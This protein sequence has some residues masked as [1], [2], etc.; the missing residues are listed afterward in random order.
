MTKEWK[1][2]DFSSDWDSVLKKEEA[3][4]PNYL[5][6]QNE[7]KNMP[8]YLSS[9]YEDIVNRVKHNDKYADHSKINNLDR[10]EVLYFI[11]ILLYIL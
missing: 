3:F 8:D 1:G 11:H 2:A 6:N 5:D 7:L 10:Y 9:G 4:Y